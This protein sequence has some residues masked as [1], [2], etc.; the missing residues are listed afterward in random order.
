MVLGVDNLN[1]YYAVQLKS[2]RLKQLQ[3]HSGFQFSELSIHTEDYTK[4]HG[5]FRPEILVHLAAQAGVRYSIDNPWVYLESNVIGFQ[6]LL[7]TL[8]AYPVRHFIFAS[9]SSVY[10]KNTEVPYKVTDRTDQP[11]SLYAATKKSN[12]L[13]GSTYAH[14]FKIPMTGLRF[15]TVYGSWGR[16]D[17]AYFS[18][19]KKILEGAPIQVF[20]HG[21]LKRDFTHIQ[22]IVESIRRLI[23]LPPSGD[24]P[25]RLL[26]IGASQPV[27]LM[28]FIHTLEDILGKKAN[29]EMKPM[30]PGDVLQTFADTRELEELTG[31]KPSLSLKEGLK[32]FADWY[33]SSDAGKK[34]L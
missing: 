8:R 21:Q 31:H 12:E 15:F 2:D 13:I 28:D 30:Q 24:V 11:V 32:E 19:T 9:S 25:Y 26:N 4:A 16:P 14:L 17:M 29:L 5:D 3:K 10:G 6:R 22:D 27:E 1:D 33:R 7:E 34:Y 20:N 23:H 18:F